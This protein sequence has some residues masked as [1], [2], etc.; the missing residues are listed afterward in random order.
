MSSGVYRKI[1][2]CVPKLFFEMRQDETGGHFPNDETGMRLLVSG[3]VVGD[4]RIHT[5]LFKNE[6][7]EREIIL[8]R[9]LG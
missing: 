7:N 2:V 4:F 9:L 8:W 5:P 1:E 6:Q 3:P